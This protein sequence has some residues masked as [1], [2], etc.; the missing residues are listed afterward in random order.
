MLIMILVHT[1]LFRN[2]PQSIFNGKRRKRMEVEYKKIEKLTDERRAD[3]I[4]ELTLRA[5]SLILQCN[6]LLILV[7]SI[8]GGVGYFIP[9]AGEIAGQDATSSNAFVLASSRIDALR[10]KRDELLKI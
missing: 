4:R 1:F 7:V 3:R 6:L 10:Q 2:I 9:I 5:N 8:V